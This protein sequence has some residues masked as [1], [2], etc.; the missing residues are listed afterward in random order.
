MNPCGTRFAPIH[1]L[2]I[3]SVGWGCRSKYVAFVSCWELYVTILRR[4]G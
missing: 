2:K 4:K 1:D 3:W